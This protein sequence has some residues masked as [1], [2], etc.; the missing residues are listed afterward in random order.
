MRGPRLLA[1]SNNRCSGVYFEFK[2]KAQIK[3]CYKQSLIGNLIIHY[4]N[5]YMNLK[6]INQRICKES[7]NESVK[8]EPMNLKRMNQ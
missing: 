4:L 3:H 8:N 2:K 5:Q 7:T 6:I 1:L